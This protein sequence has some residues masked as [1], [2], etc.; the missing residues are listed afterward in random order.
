VEGAAVKGAEEYEQGTAV[1]ATED[2]G[3]DGQHKAALAWVTPSFNVS[4]RT[5][6]GRLKMGKTTSFLD[7]I[8]AFAD[9]LCGARPS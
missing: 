6:I 8:L 4:P 3:W 2:S 1:A 9:C 7:S 5:S